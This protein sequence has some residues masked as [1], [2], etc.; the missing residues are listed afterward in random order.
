[1]PA[2]VM[3]SLPLIAKTCRLIFQN[4]QFLEKW[5]VLNSLSPCQVHCSTVL[6]FCNSILSRLA[7]AYLDTLIRSEVKN[8]PGVSQFLLP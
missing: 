4:I 2:R 3:G 5:N 7:S 6:L 8:S 1:M